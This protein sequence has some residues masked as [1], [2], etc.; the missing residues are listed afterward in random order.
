MD[1]LIAQSWISSATRLSAADARRAWEFYEKYEHNPAHPSLSLERITQARDK[2]TWSGRISQSLRAV[3]HQDGETRVVL[4]AGPHDDAYAWASTHTFERNAATGVLQIVESPEVIAQQVPALPARVPGRFDAHDDAYLISLGLPTTWLPVIR[5]IAL[6]AEEQLEDVLARL[7]EE[8][9]ERLLDVACG[10]LVTPPVPP[11]P[12]QPP[13]ASPDTRRR[14]FQLHD[15]TE[16][17]Q[18]LA[19][20]LATWLVFLHP[21]QRRFATSV[22]NGPLKVTGSAGTG[23]TVVALHR[24]RHLAA[25]G[26]RVLVTSF[27]STM[28]ERLDDGLRLLCSPDELSHVTVR[29]VHGQARALLDAAGEHWRTPQKDQ[30]DKDK[31]EL[32]AWMRQARAHT[33]CAFDLELLESEWVDVVQAQGLT[34]WDDYRRAS[35]AGRGTPLSVKDRQQVWAALERLQTTLRDHGVLDFPSLCRRA[36]ALLQTGVVASPYDAVIVDEA[37]D[38]GPQELLLVAALAGSGCPDHAAGAPLNLTLVGDGGQRVYGRATS[39]KAL[40]IDVRGR[41]HVL[42]LNYR[43]TEQIRRFADRI[44]REQADNLDGERD[45]RS[46][47]RNLF[48]GPE[49]VLRGFANAEAEYDY[50]VGEIGRLL[51]QQQDRPLDAGEIAVFARRNSQ[52]EELRKRLRAAR[53][54]CARLGAGHE[55]PSSQPGGVTLAT[56]HRAKGLEYKAVFIVGVSDTLI[57]EGQAYRHLTDPVAR[58]EALQREKQLLYVSITRARDEVYLTWADR[59]SRFLPGD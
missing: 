52:L 59:R 6:D 22:A 15:E 1:V 27:V 28:C 43:T 31:D 40:G 44:V 46:G 12:H 14:F 21:S 57:P 33:G 7:P 24:A 34:T 4:Y 35:R 30:K 19:A 20:P 8:V 54:P 23:K 49:P 16:L 18:L 26:R 11:A 38:L 17:R 48:D 36:R 39:L 45:D 55:G 58:E 13:L 3:L 56:M 50:V 9:A 42:R 10:K 5:K 25:Q 29:T 53:L 51:D 2:N 41:S 47:V 32:R 37:Q